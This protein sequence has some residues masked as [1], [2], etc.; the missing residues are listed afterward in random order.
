MKKYLILYIDKFLCL[1][2]LFWV[3][4][5]VFS[6][7]WSL[8]T[9]PEEVED[10]KSLVQRSKQM[11]APPPKEEEKDYLQQYNTKVNWDIDDLNAQS[12]F[13]YKHEEVD[14]G[15]LQRPFM[16]KLEEH[17]PHFIKVPGEDGVE[18]CIFPGCSHKKE[19][20]SVY[21]GKCESLNS[22]EVTV[23]TVSLEWEA[24]KDFR[25][26]VVN[27][28]VIQ[29]RVVKEEND[30]WED[31]LDKEGNSLKIYGVDKNQ[32]L[33]EGGAD[34]P[35]EEVSGFRL[36]GLPS[37]VAPHQNVEPQEPK[38]LKFSYFDFNLQADTEYEYRIKAMGISMRD[39]RTEIE[40]FWSDPIKLK[41]KLDQG[42]HFVRYLPGLRNK[43]GEYL[44]KDGKVVSPDKVY[45]KIKKLFNLPWSPQK[46]FVEYEHRN[47]IP[48]DKDLSKVGL[49]VR[50]YNINSP[51][52]H[53]VY[54]NE[55]TEELMCVGD[56]ME[57][58]EGQVKEELDKN[59]KRW[60]R[61]RVEKD[62]ST[63]W[64]VLEVKEEVSV[65]Q[66]VQRKL[67]KFGKYE[68]GT[69]EKKQYRYFLIA[70]DVKTQKIMKVELE[71][72]DHSVRLL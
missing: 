19:L 20:P 52:G 6:S 15:I 17:E 60:K 50:R 61:Y 63:S 24:P 65:E 11:K 16:K 4:S 35:A 37:D 70:Q 66:V 14:L 67:T 36:P 9:T 55:K 54:F 47:I 21:I 22:N 38:D 43:K 25:E 59:K 29:R 48:G 8:S 62:F 26:A 41:T 46:Y 12:N 7:I 58:T 57:R 34:K 44:M 31:I 53:P 71:R 27:H 2:I 28:C 10:G 40:G 56:E 72:E 49:L 1:L 13:F 30:E 33:K 39:H 23:M 69:I 3:L 51:D 68:E 64:E 18:R 32:I 45:V 5:N 42:I